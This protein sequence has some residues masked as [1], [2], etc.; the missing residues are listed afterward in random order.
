[1][2]GASTGLQLAVSWAA[3]IS[4]L[5]AIG[6]VIVVRRQMG[7]GE[8]TLLGATS[9][10]C[11]GAMSQLLQLLIEKPHLRPYLYESVP[12]P[13]PSDFELRQQVLAIGAQYAD[14]F[15]AV[16]QQGSLGNVPVQEYI[17]VWKGF[18]QTMLE[19]SFVIRDYIVDH[20]AWY[21]PELYQLAISIGPK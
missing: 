11:Y 1:M 18:M 12:L 4:S 17:H 20:K 5:A 21:T 6:G 9:Q 13:D 7:Q 16:L 2:L 14:F 19:S 8:R 15:D 3:L 10:F